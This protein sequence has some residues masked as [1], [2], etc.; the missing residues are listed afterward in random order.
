MKLNESCES[1]SLAFEHKD[2]ELELTDDQKGFLKSIMH[3]TG[4][5]LGV[6]L[7]MPAEEAELRNHILEA[8]T[9]I[10][11]D[12]R[13]QI[14]IAVELTIMKQAITSPLQQ[15]FTDTELYGENL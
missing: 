4:D 14:Q 11:L 5:S 12:A 10:Y 3:T 13:R 2:L 1:W 8:I 6:V 15:G 9:S 7:G